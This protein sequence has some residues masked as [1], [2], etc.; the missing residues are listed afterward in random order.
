MLYL[1]CIT[2][3]TTRGRLLRAKTGL[4]YDDDD[5]GLV[6]YVPFNII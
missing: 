5:D 1:N 2:S 4:N 3:C 6:F